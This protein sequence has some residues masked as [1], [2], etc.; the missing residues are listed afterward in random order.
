M[1]TIRILISVAINCNWTIFQMDV[2]NAFLQ[3]DLEEEVYMSIPPGFRQ[4]N[5]RQVC[6]LNKPIYGLK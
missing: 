6:K 5:P 2:K 1:N 4:K 3:G